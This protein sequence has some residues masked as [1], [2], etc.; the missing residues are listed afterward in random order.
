MG[1]ISHYPPEKDNEEP[2]AVDSILNNQCIGT[3]WYAPPERHRLLEAWAGGTNSADSA[4]S[5][6]K[7]VIG[8]G[9]MWSVGVV[10]YF[11]L[12]GHNPFRH[13]LKYHRDKAKV[14][15]EMLRL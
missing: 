1:G 15:S 4:C 6:G 10:A 11:L 12:V 8:R 9:D 2:L 7:S 13:A 14:E 5:D 3:L